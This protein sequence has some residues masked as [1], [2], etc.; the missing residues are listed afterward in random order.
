[1]GERGIFVKTAGLV[2]AMEFTWIQ[3]MKLELLKKY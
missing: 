2:M 1:M 3:K